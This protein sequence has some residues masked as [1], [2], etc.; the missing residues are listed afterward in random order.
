MTKFLDSGMKLQ[1]ERLI[2]KK[3]KVHPASEK[4]ILDALA[5]EGGSATFAG[6]GARTG[7]DD[8][9]MRRYL[10]VMMKRGTIE[11]DPKTGRWTPT[12]KAK[13]SDE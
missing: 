6:I 13:V 8:M 5:K 3:A 10:A 11:L 4:R 1:R 12:P 9:T 7:M 2:T